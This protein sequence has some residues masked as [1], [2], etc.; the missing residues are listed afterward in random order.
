M[1]EHER[2]N[3]MR[4]RIWDAPVRTVHWFV[5]A[6]VVVAWLTRHGRYIDLH[7]AA[8]YAL[9]ALLAF[10]VAW[11]FV[12]THHARF[13]NFAY[14]PRAAMSYLFGLA[15]GRAEDF[16]GHNPA[17][18]WSVFALLA[19]ELAIVVT[20]LVAIAGMHELG[21]L[22]GAVGH[23]SADL[24]VTWHEWLAWAMLALVAAHLLG[25]V[26]SSVAHRENLVAAMVTG[27]K[28][29]HTDAEA[30]VKSHA[31]VALVLALAV[32]GSAAAH[33]LWVRESAA[34]QA[35]AAGVALDPLWR[36]ECD[37]CHLPYAPCMLPAA[38]WDAT[39]AGQSEHFGEDLALGEAALRELQRISR[40]ASANEPWACWKTRTS[41]SAGE[42]PLE[43]SLTPYWKRAHA[44]LAPA[45]I[46]NPP[47]VAGAHDC[48][49]CHRDA[50]SSIFH[51][52]MIQI[53]Q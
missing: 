8:G 2:V 1:V 49:A 13:R 6:L 4:A 44:A 22:A 37:S 3:D 14:S 33:V 18:S 16:E 46:K 5:V 52:R 39:F 15:R 35:P 7:A 20:G 40:A 53:P 28:R 30:T 17:G 38:S 10:R 43:I 23:A 19:F 27:Y 32:G 36:K 51:P 34:K 45:Q 9:L 47:R 50:L 24:A 48:G 42:A 11:G 29:R 21:P 41:V 12:G 26:A 25:V 31:L